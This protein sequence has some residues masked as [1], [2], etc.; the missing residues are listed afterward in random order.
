MILIDNLDGDPNEFYALVREEVLKRE[1]PGI[2]FIDSNEFRSKGI[3]SSDSAPALYV[4]DGMSQVKI[5][6]YQFARSF[7]VSART[8]WQDLKMAEKAEDT[9]TNYLVGVQFDCFTESVNRAI[10]SALSRYLEQRQVTMP[11]SINPKDIFQGS[12]AQR[13]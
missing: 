4:R 6:A 12:E 2:E 10:S 3:F 5:F 9:L 7:H 11:Q 13:K 1:I 8:S